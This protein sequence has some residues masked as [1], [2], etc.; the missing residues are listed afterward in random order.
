MW[1]KHTEKKKIREEQH[2]LK[3]E[4]KRD[5]CFVNINVVYLIQSVTMA[6]PIAF[7]LIRS[8]TY[9]KIH[10]AR[11]RQDQM[12]LLYEALTFGGV[13]MKSDFYR[14][15]LD[16]EPDLLIDPAIFVDIHKYQLIRRV[17]KVMP[18]LHE[19]FYELYCDTRIKQMTSQDQMRQLYQDLEEAEDSRS[20]KSDFYRILLNQDPDVVN[21]L[22]KNLSTSGYISLEYKPYLVYHLGKNL[23]T[24]GYISLEYKPYLVYHLGKNL[25]PSGYISL[26]YKPYLVYHLGKNLSTSGYIS[27]EYKPYLVYHL[28]KNLS[29]SGYISLEYKPYLVYH[30]GKNLSPSGYISLEYKPYL[31]YHL[32]KNLSTSVLRIPFGPTVLGD[33]NETRNIT[34]AN[35][36]SDN[37]KV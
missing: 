12:R 34:Q 17:T 5:V 22:G 6:I 24:S 13:K 18:I 35:Y 26:E 14:I 3:R 31:V 28:G 27:L 21:D 23:S 19:L 4:V 10:A 29:T 8:E 11:T 16:L 9:S 30:L 36:N 32:G 37:L 15:L 33:G 25:S 1:R 7:Y 20:V 2:K